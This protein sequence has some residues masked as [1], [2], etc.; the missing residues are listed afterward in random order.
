MEDQTNGHSLP[1]PP[2][3]APPGLPHIYVINSDEA[4][5]ET[6]GDLLQDARVRVTLEQMRPNIAVTLENLHSARPD[7][8]ILDIVPHR[9]DPLLL[10]EHMLVDADLCQIPI[11][12]AST[13]PALAEQI[14]QTYRPLVRDVLRK[15]FAI[16]VFIQTLQRLQVPIQAI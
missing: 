15:P 6:I 11:L 4:F 12:A 2:T 16:E 7:L 10:L 5:L 1:L 9:R 3:P 13:N 14:A 8:L